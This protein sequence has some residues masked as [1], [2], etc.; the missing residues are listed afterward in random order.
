MAAKHDKVGPIFGRIDLQK[1]V[2]I[3]RALIL[4][5]ALPITSS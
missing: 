1:L 3:E 5:S 2:E 4:L